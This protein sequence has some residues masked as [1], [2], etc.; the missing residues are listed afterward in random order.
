MRPGQWEFAKRVWDIA[1]IGDGRCAGR[2]FGPGVY[3]CCVAP[4]GTPSRR[5][6]RH[7]CASYLFGQQSLAPA[8]PSERL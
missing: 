6:H 4:V 8:F 7:D 5:H 3:D 2:L 1:H